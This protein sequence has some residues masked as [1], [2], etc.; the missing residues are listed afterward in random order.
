MSERN[1]TIAKT[2][3]FL[4]KK[5]REEK[6]VGEDDEEEEDICVSRRNGVLGIVFEVV[7]GGR[8]EEEMDVKE[9]GERKGAKNSGRE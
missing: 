4:R 3:S 1:E 5:T 8:R 7:E 2:V 9:E 6:E